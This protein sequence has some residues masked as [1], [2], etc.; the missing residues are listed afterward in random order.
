MFRISPPIP[1]FFITAI[2]A[3]ETMNCPFTRI[4]YRRSH[5][6]RLCS[7]IDREMLIPALFTTMS[8]PPKASEAFTKAASALAA[9]VTFRRV[10]AAASFPNI[11]S[12]SSRVVTRRVSSI[13]LRITQAPS[14][15]NFRAMALPIP[16][17]EP[18]TRATLPARAFGLG[19]RCSLASSSSQ[20]S[21]LK[22]SWRG[23]AVYSE[24]ASAP[25]ITLMAFT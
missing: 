4:S 13:S 11:F 24:M 8:T 21:I 10:A 17:P 7:S 6:S 19:I 12:N 14:C 15:A 18:V 5:S 16:P 23:K 25:R 1:C 9:S 3:F 20:Y 22:A 2:P